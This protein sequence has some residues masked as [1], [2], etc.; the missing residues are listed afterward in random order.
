MTSIIW[1]NI[2]ISRCVKNTDVIHSIKLDKS[3]NRIAILIDS[4][5]KELVFAGMDEFIGFIKM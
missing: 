4:N 5:G 3:G 2:C 1:E